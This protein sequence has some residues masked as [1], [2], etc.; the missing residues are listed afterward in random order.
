MPS[1]EKPIETERLLLRKF[2]HEDLPD[3]FEMV[4]NPAVVR[5]EPY[6]PMSMKEAA[7]ELAA[8]RESGE[9]TMAVLK[10]SGK[11][12]GNIYLGKREYDAMEIGFLFNE[13]YWGKGYAAE[14]CGAL[15]A[16][17]FSNG[18]NRI[19]AHCD[20]ENTASWRLLE[21]LGFVREGHLRRNVYFRTDAEGRPV[22]KDTYIYA[23]LNDQALPDSRPHISDAAEHS[24]GS[25]FENK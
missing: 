5:Y 23:L 13:A 1:E 9:F 2:R 6:G 11:V 12:I 10:D 18:V 22:W 20:P 7:S 8:R 3:F 25:A 17:A 15:I 16:Q 21:R 4:S 24:N 14:G 19:Y